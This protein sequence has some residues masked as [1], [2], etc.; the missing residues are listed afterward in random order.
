[1]VDPQCKEAKKKNGKTPSQLFDEEH[2]KGIKEVEKW[3]KEAATSFSVIDILI[4]TVIF[5]GLLTLPGG[6][7]QSS[8]Y[9]IFRKEKLFIL[10]VMADLI[11]L[12]SAL[13]HC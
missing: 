5:P 4:I 7:D 13:F 3:S 1:M 8:G 11:S 12:V 6:N 2:E 10:Y 9:P